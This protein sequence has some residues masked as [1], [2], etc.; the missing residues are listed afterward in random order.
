[1]PSSSA[2][3][4]VAAVARQ[5]MAVLGHKTHRGGIRHQLLSGHA[6]CAHALDT[7]II[8]A[9]CREQ[10]C[11]PGSGPAGKL[12]SPLCMRDFQRKAQ[13]SD[14]SNPAVPSLAQ[15]FPPAPA[16]AVARRLGR[17]TLLAK[18]AEKMRILQVY[19]V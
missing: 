9:Q 17:S 3:A 16:A 8:D 6:W 14:L 10:P 11:K 13:P 7:M 4:I 5:Y 12:V 2:A 1:M 15:P 19:P 18:T